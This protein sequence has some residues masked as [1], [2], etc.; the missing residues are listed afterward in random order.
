VP[1]IKSAGVLHFGS[2]P[3]KTPARNEFF[4]THKEFR[5][6]VP[7]V[8]LEVGTERQFF[9][10]T[11]DMVV[12]LS[13]IGITVADHV[14]YLTITSRGAIRVMP[15]RRANADGQQNEYDR[16]EKSDWSKEWWSG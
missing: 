4:R 6:I 11:S 7:I 15:V 1:I 3:R 5:P 9:A 8:D 14:L 13:G 10:V 2:E 16:R 12:N